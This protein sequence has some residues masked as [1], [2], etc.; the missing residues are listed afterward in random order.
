MM[1]IPYGTDAPLYHRPYATIGVIAVNLVLAIAVPKD[2]REHWA[3]TMGDGFHPLQWVT[4]SFLH[5]GLIHAAGSMSL[6]WVFGLIVEGKV[7]PFWFLGSYLAVGILHGATVQAAGWNTVPQTFDTFG[8]EA[9]VCGILGMAVVWAPL[10]TITTLWVGR[11]LF[12]WFAETYEIP[13]ALYATMAVV[14]NIISLV[15]RHIGGLLFFGLALGNL[16]GIVWGMILGAAMLAARLVDCEGWDLY[17]VLTNRA[18][19]ILADRRKSRRRG[20]RSAL[21]RERFALSAKAGRKARNTTVEEA[22]EAVATLAPAPQSAVAR[23][24]HEIEQGRIDEA[25]RIY[26]RTARVVT[27]W[28]GET[29]TLALIKSL[30]ATNRFVESLP[31][32]RDYCRNFPDRADRMRLKLAQILIRDREHPTHALRVL[33]EIAEGALPT[34]LE[35]VRSSLAKQ[36]RQMIDE[37]VLELEDAE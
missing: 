29:D 22:P 23:I 15:L 28:P 32:M 16:S 30:H 18:G 2:A 17:L 11:T 10:N 35:T 12:L 7:G 1:L 31:L 13:V 21:L 37:G 24:Q 9:S 25:L 8:S 33:D 34:S 6:L 26:D 19:K 14:W 27:G 5:A 3:L 20:P 4:H 36:A